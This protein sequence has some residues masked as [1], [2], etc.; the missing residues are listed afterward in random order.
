MTG[1]GN[2]LFHLGWDKQIAH[3]DD[4]E[5]ETTEVKQAV[6]CQVSFC[7]GSDEYQYVSKDHQSCIGLS[8]EYGISLAS[9]KG[10][11]GVDSCVAKCEN[12]KYI[13][14]SNIAR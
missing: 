13:C 8:I 14:D 7:K 6:S 2:N 10:I 1:W 3:P 5:A 4:S 9:N 12:G 11:D